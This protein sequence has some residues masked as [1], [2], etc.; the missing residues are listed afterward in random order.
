[1]YS[2]K[3]IRQLLD[4]FMDGKTTVEEEQKIGKWFAAHEK[5]SPD[6][7]DYKQMFAYFD[8]GM[9]L[10][11]D[12]R[13]P[14]LVGKH[15][16]LLRNINLKVAMLAAAC[17][18]AVILMT[19]RPLN[20]APQFEVAQVVCSVP[21]DTTSYRIE[22]GKAAKPQTDSVGNTK[23]KTK[24]HYRKYMYSPAPPQ[25]L[26]AEAR[27]QTYIDS[28]SDAIDAIVAK[29]VEDA[30]NENEESYRQALKSTAAFENAVF[31]ETLVAAMEE[32][33]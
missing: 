29:C 6:L 33:Y 19:T 9:P 4:R 24:R 31:E 1:M 5:V 3:G 25:A 26:Y 17:V 11:V 28:L 13:K 7:E 21:S 12:S 30:R 23:P 27:K 20:T 18:V 22:A 15:R 14:A 2:E 16:T 8:E 10:D 32:V